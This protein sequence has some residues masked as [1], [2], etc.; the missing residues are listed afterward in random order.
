MSAARAA[1]LLL[2]GGALAVAAAAGRPAGAPQSQPAYPAKLAAGEGSELA[3]SH[4]LMCHSAMLIAQQ[5]KDST[6]WEKTIALMEK[7]SAPLDSTSH[8]A[9]HRYLLRSY[10]PRRGD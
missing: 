3:E 6:G 4:C 5:A 10:G 1:A 8:R 2:I 7:W 9:L